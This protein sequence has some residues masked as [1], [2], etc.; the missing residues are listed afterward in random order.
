MLLVFLPSIAI[1]NTPD[2]KKAWLD[3]HN[4]ARAEVGV[5]PLELDEGLLL[6]SAKR[7]ALHLKKECA[8]Y[9][10]KNSGYGENLAYSIG[11]DWPKPEATV[12]M[13]TDE[14]EFYDPKNPRWC[15]GGVCGHY[16]QIVWSSSKYLACYRVACRVP[17]GK[18]KDAQKFITVCR[19]DPFGNII[20]RK[21][22]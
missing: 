15:T 14:K 16:T 21:P 18:W 9:H 3:A 4:K 6:K 17:S 19:Y 12:K 8:M 10:E 7:W 2:I 22:Y 1:A 11:N 13:W 5:R 20:G